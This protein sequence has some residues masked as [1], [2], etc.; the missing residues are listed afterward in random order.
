MIQPKN[1]SLFLGNAFQTIF[2]NVGDKAMII[3]PMAGEGSRFKGLT[4]K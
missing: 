3:I 4:T 2:R 1:S